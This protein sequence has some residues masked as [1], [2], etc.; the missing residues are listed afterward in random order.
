MKTLAELLNN[1]PDNPIAH[2]MLDKNN[3][4]VIFPGYTQDTAR[5][6]FNLS[7]YYVDSC[8]GGC[9]WLYRRE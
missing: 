4:C 3:T 7:D 8:Q 2:E 1:N 5:E 6:I 9:Y